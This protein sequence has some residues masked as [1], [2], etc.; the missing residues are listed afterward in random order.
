MAEK[1]TT[2]PEKIQPVANCIR[3]WEGML[4]SDKAFLSPSTVILIEDTVKHL[5][6]RLPIENLGKRLVGK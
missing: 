4:L 6:T 3:F 5:R 2:A 1:E